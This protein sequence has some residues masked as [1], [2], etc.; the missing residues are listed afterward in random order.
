M[1]S[2]RRA[3]RTI[4]PALTVLVLAGGCRS[5]E[6][7]PRTPY[8]GSRFSSAGTHA[9]SHQS[10]GLSIQ[11][12]DQR[13]LRSGAD[14][15][16]VFLPRELELSAA[17]IRVHAIPGTLVLTPTQTPQIQ[18]TSHTNDDGTGDVTSDACPPFPTEVAPA[19]PPNLYHAELNLPPAGP[20]DFPPSVYCPH[21]QVVR[22]NV[23]HV[24]EVKVLDYRPWAPMGI[25]LQLT[26][27]DGATLTEVAGTTA[28]WTARGEELV[29]G[30]LNFKER[31]RRKLIHREVVGKPTEGHNSP[32]AMLQ[33]VAEEVAAWYAAAIMPQPVIVEPAPRKSFGPFVI[34]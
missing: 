17:G 18:L 13:L 8:I 27:R 20:T 22:L 21:P 9:I 19:T 11:S 5:H 29:G 26:A 16:A 12:P 24:L 4:L 15:L 14:R 10:V 32:D 33:I 7:V 3:R 2:M 23:E 31:K 6:P 1:M 30:C 25:S 34:E 28:T